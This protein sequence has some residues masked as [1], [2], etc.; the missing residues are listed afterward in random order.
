MKKF[1]VRGLLFIVVFMVSMNP[2]PSPMNRLPHF[3]LVSALAQELGFPPEAEALVAKAATWDRYQVRFSLEAKEETG[4]P[5]QLEGSLVVRPPNQRRLEIRLVGEEELSQILVADGEVEWQYFPQVAT[6]YR[7]THVPTV[8]GPHRPFENVYPRSLKLVERFEEEA[9]MLLR[10][11]GR[12]LPSI[13]EGAPILIET[14]LID[15]AEKDGLMRRILFLDSDGEAVLTQRYYDVQ[16][17]APAQEGEFTFSPPEGASL[18]EIGPDEL[19][20]GL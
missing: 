17:N 14:V 2:E 12:P 9:E 4:E 15:V 16:V 20:A 1:V 13:V 8:P 5:V 19:E 18:I 3:Q 7:L 10:F 6:V 11:E